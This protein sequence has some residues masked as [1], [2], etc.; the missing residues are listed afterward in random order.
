[1]AARAALAEGKSTWGLQVAADALT[2]VCGVLALRVIRSVAD[3]QDR[4]FNAIG[5]ES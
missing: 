4:L 1:M 5:P 3:A 2:V